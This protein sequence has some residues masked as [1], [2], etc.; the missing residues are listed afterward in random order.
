M[1]LFHALAVVIMTLQSR[2]QKSFRMYSNSYRYAA[3][4]YILDCDYH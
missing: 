3:C 2:L 1:A 4:A